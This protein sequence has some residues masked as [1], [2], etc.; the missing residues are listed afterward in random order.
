MYVPEIQCGLFWCFGNEKQMVLFFIVVTTA[1]VLALK[2]R[3]QTI[4]VQPR[5]FS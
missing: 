1:R 2:E 3:Q 5:L 4:T